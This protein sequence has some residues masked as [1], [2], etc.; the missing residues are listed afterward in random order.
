MRLDIYELFNGQTHLV[1][2]GQG[3]SGPSSEA[4]LRAVN[5]DGSRVYF[6]SSERLT[7]IDMDDAIDAYQSADL[8]PRPAG[9]DAAEHAPGGRLRP[10]HHAGRGPRTFA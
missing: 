2:I 10:V 5:D 1:S 7:D 4:I 3:G 9:G 6:D 8:Y